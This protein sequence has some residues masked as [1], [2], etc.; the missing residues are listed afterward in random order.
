[1]K[2]LLV[3]LFAALVFVAPALAQESSPQ[4]L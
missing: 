1:M 2:H 4:R 3:M